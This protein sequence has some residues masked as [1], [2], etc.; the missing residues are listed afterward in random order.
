MPIALAVLRFRN[1][2]T[3]V[4]CWDRQLA[5][6][7]AFENARG[8]D[9]HLAVGVAEGAA[10]AHQ[11]AGGDEFAVF[12]DRRNRVTEGERS[13][14]LAAGGEKRMSRD[15]EPPCTQLGETCEDAIEVALATRV[16]AMEIDPEHMRRETPLLLVSLLRAGQLIGQP[17]VREDTESEAAFS[18]AFKKM[19]GVAPA[20]WRRRVR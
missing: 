20:T 10:I 13:E 1:I 17:E 16:E 14:L 4:D 6:L 19:I 9:A 12:V 18:R 8:V 7:Y 5:R 2:S 15:D 3:F 11:A